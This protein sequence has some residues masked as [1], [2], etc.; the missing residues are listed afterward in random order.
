MNLFD[1]KC[2][3]VSL[4]VE[5]KLFINI[6]VTATT[7]QMICVRENNRTAHAAHPLIRFLAVL[8]ETTPWNDHHCAFEDS[9][10][11]CIHLSAIPSSASIVSFANNVYTVKMEISQNS[12][13]F[14]RSCRRH[15]LRSLLFSLSFRTDEGQ[16]GCHWPTFRHPWRESHLRTSNICTNTL[17]MTSRSQTTGDATNNFSYH[18]SGIL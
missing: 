16:L 13:H 1:A 14:P 4:S 10:I 18:V 9:V 6:V 11:F 15:C 8:C 5:T 3:R 17:I 2:L 12:F 7:P